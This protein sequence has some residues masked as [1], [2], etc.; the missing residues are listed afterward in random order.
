MPPLL[1]PL[2]NLWQRAEAIPLPFPE[3]I[4][5]PGD[6]TAEWLTSALRRH[7]LDVTVRSFHSEPVGT[8]QMAHNERIF[9]DYETEAQSAPRTAV[10]KFPA[11]GEQSRAAGARGA[12]R[13]ETLFY[14]ELAASLP[15]RTPDCFYGAISDDHTTFTLLLEDLAPARQ[16]DQIGGGSDAEIEAAVR[17]L[18]GL[19]APRWNDPSLDQLDWAFQS[20]SDEFALYIEM[21]TP[22]FIE[23]YQSRLSEED[24][25]TLRSY[26]AGVRRWLEIRPTEKTLVHGDYRLDNLMFDA[27]GGVVSVAAVDWQT[28]SV[29]CG[30]QDLAYL[31]GNSSPPE[32]RRGHES[33]MLEV[34]R[35][36]MS[37][38]GVERSADEVYADYV[39]GSFHGPAI[40]M[41]GSLSVEQTDRG[42]EMFMVM[43][44]RA[45]AQIRELN[46]LDL[47]SE[48][49][50]SAATP[51]ARPILPQASIPNND[52]RLAGVFRRQRPFVTYAGREG[53][54]GACTHCG[55]GAARFRERLLPKRPVGG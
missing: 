24:A 23:R 48:I 30:G 21:G 29:G 16:G 52:E 36:S 38:L 41:L 45:T 13:A 51:P 4:V 39:Y 1:P 5:D 50:R 46:A 3:V 43:A 11:P 27:S 53:F 35:E 22:V 17:N 20:G 15:I 40:T 31:L 28:L 47:I 7:G 33:H 55:P 19:H 49:V 14:T 9:L 34:Y 32:Q 25:A 6:L 37:A 18:A 8:G 42:D 26:A 2:P 54:A 12:Y 10:G 44:H